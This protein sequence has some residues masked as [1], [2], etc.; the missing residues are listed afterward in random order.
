MTQNDNSTKFQ[1]IKNKDTGSAKIYAECIV[2]IHPQN[3][4]WNSAKYPLP[5]LP[6]TGTGPQLV[7]HVTQKYF[8]LIRCG[9]K[10]VEYRE[11]KKYWQARIEGKK[12]NSIVIS[13]RQATKFTDP[14]WLI[15]PWWPGAIKK[16]FRNPLTDG[17]GDVFGNLQLLQVYEITLLPK[18]VEEVY[19]DGYE[20]KEQHRDTPALSA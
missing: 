10:T 20:I 18:T 14:E 13:V 2:P 19:P 1:G 6:V 17:T 5:L 16:S 8:D 9:K 15:F 3:V 11:V 12:F 7:L 4:P